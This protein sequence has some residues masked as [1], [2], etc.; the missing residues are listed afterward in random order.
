MKIKKDWFKKAEAWL[1][2]SNRL[3]HLVLGVGIGVLSDSG[4]CAALAGTCTAGAMEV[5]DKMHGGEFDWIDFALTEVGVALGYGVR[6]LV[7]K[8][9]S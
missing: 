7:V 9:I 2:E 8:L 5:K 6:V 1:K 3:K 4:Y